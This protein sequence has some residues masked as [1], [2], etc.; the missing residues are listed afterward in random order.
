MGSLWKKAKEA[1]GMNICVFVPRVQ[2]EEE[3]PRTEIGKKSETW[4]GDVEAS[5]AVSGGNSRLDSDS[6]VPIKATSNSSRQLMSESRSSSG[7]RTCATCAICLGNMKAGRGALFTAECSHVFHFACIASNVKHGN[8]VC[9]ICRAKWKELPFL[10]PLLDLPR[11]RARSNPVIWPQED[12][13]LRR[14]ARASSFNRQHHLA[15]PYT[16]SEPNDYDDDE[17]VEFLSETVKNSEHRSTRTVDIKAYPECSAIPKLA[18]EESFCILIHLKAPCAVSRTPFF[19]NSSLT[20][21]LPSRAP[22]DLVTVLD[23]SGSMA[24]TKLALLKRAMGF[25]IQ[26]LSPSDRLSVIAFSSTARRLFPLRRMTEAGRLYALQAINS[27]FSS[28][29]TNIAEGLRKGAKV[30]EERKEKNPVCSIILLSDGQDT[31]TVSSTGGRVNRLS[32][33]YRS[34]VPSSIL[35]GVGH[36]IPIHVFGF[37]ADHDSV[38]MHSISETSGGTFSF[39]ESELAIQDAFAQCIGGLLSVLVQELIVKIER[40]NPDVHLTSIQ[41]GSYANQVFDGANGLISVG[42]LYAEEERDFLVSVSVPPATAEETVLLKFYCSYRD[43]LS[44]EMVN[45]EGEDVG[46]RRPEHVAERVMSAE[47]ERERIRVQAAKAMAEARVAAER[48]ALSEAV[49]ILESQRSILSLSAVG[50]SGDRLC[51]SMDAELREMQERMES[52]Q[53]YEESGRAYMLSGLSSH[54]W[55]R[56]TTRGTS[57]DSSGLAHSY[58]TPLMVDMLHR[59]QTLLLSPRH[60]MPVIRPTNSFSSRGV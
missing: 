43:P 59:S 51:V 49:L 55:Q 4:D 10:T 11:G 25:V 47:V 56:A 36:R 34:L 7:K 57:I 50:R 3:N 18:S 37:G 6:L 41:S 44:N 15:S 45:M 9:P 21:S 20:A 14:P 40:V 27:L 8:R 48:G 35:S 17:P 33:D 58:Q 24:G 1:M 16:I 26:N 46:I 31:Y 60:P 54:S 23:I 2:D 12:G 30:I 53:K 32:S 19:Q 52:R 13:S 5:L 39:I 22:V 38:S 42:D 28:G 29:G